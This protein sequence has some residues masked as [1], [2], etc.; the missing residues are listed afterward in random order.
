M[1]VRG[2]PCHLVHLPVGATYA[3]ASG[4]SAG[5]F[6]PP[7][8]AG[9]LPP[10][11]PPPQAGP[12]PR[13][14]PLASVPNVSGVVLASDSGATRRAYASVTVRT[15]DQFSRSLVTDVGSALVRTVDTVG[16]SEIASTVDDDESIPI[17]DDT[18]ETN[19]NAYL[20][21]VCAGDER[22]MSSHPMKM[23]RHSSYANARANSRT[24]V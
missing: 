23:A 12:P 18:L 19:L 1:R 15:V 2:D 21:T 16:R 3:L 8:P 6:V 5:V 9:R 20:Q 13:S 4:S 7:P 17:V 24:S 14:N 11:V 10:R 22:P